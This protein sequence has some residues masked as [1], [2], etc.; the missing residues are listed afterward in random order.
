MIREPTRATLRK[1]GWTLDDWK[2][3][4][5]LQDGTC[6]VCRKVPSSGRLMLDHAHVKGWSKMKPERRRDYV[7]GL[8][9]YMCN[10]FYLARGITIEKARGVLAY[11]EAYEEKK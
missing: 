10:R 2:L 1:Y 4:V 7:R 5:L 6:A 9:C 11:L 3:Q 8:V